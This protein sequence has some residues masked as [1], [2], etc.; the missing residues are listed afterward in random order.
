MSETGD[1]PPAVGERRLALLLL[2]CGAVGLVASG[3]LLVERFQLA[4]DPTHTPSCSINPVLSCGSIMESDQASLLGF[5][6]PIIGVAAFPVLVTVG[7]ALLAGAR[8]RRWFWVGL[9]AG[10]AAGAALVAWLIVQSLYSIGALCPYCMVVW[11][12]VAILLV[13]VTVHNATSGHLGSRLAAASVVRGA[14]RWHVMIQVVLI[15]AVVGLI[16]ERF[17]YFWATLI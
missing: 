12:V 11:L 17:W 1:V 5:P 16:L 7:V 8:L 13:E 2:I 10:V 14:A 15:A 9:Q 3:I 6:N 4:L